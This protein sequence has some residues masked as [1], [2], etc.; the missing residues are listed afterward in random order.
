MNTLLGR[1]SAL[2]S[3][4]RVVL[5]VFV[6]LG[7]GGG[8]FFVVRMRGGPYAPQVAALTRDQD[9]DGLKDWEEG[10]FRT[11]PQN[12]DTDADGTPDG[13]EIKQ[14]RDPLK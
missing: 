7:L 11:D 3:R 1:I 4:A 12:P 10:I 2:S 6:V 5:V 13:E 14:N 9:A 8:L